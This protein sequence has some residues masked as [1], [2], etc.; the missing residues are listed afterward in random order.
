MSK[1]RT[2]PSRHIAVDHELQRLKGLAG[3]HEFE[4]QLEV[5]LEKLTQRLSAWHVRPQFNRRN[6]LAGFRKAN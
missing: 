1:Q 5:D 2:S 4:H 6:I 3:F